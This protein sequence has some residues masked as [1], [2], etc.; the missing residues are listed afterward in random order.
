MV[1]NI[2]LGGVTRILDV[3]KKI[4]S[5]LERCENDFINKANCNMVNAKSS[6]KEHESSNINIGWLSVNIVEKHLGHITNH[7]TNVSKQ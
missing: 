7:E 5:V 1:H 6:S 4:E 3:E 2:K